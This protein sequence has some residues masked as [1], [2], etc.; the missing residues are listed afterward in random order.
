MFIEINP[1]EA[2]EHHRGEIWPVLHIAQLELIR[3]V[4]LFSINMLLLRSLLNHC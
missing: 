2:K 4:V 3:R 1:T